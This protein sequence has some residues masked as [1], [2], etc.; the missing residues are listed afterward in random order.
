MPWRVDKKKEGYKLYNLD[1]KRYVNKT[2][3]TRQSAINARRN[4]S[5][6]YK[7]KRK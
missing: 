1:K 4:Y 6:Y 7:N 2:F 5:N 3:K